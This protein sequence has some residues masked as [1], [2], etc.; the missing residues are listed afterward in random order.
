MWTD[1]VISESAGRE[2]IDEGRASYLLGLPKEQL[3]E[4]SQMSGLGQ[5]AAGKTTLRLVF[6][7]EDLCEL[8]RLIDGP[9]C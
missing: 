2:L 6:T 3:R 8:C 4:I 7:Y 1:Q 5:M 9:V